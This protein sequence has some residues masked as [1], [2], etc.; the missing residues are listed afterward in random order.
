[1]VIDESLYA[2][3]GQI[4]FPRLTDRST[5]NELL[6]SGYRCIINYASVF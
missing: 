5:H 3:T 4:L 6:I 1:M 2:Y